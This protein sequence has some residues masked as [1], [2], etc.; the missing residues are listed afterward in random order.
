[1]ALRSVAAEAWG[2]AIA[3]AAHPRL[4]PPAGPTRGAVAVLP[5]RGGMLAAVSRA[6]GAPAL[7]AVAL[8]GILGCTL[9][10]LLPITG[11]PIAGLAKA[12]LAK[13]LLAISL[14]AKARSGALVLGIPPAVALVGLMRLGAPG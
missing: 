6:P 5:K 9:V 4:A 11:L 8:A 7:G 14:L 1:A 10:T 3:L 12:G 2:A 13:T